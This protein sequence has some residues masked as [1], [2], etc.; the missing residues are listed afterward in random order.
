MKWFECNVKGKDWERLVQADT[1]GGAKATY[2]RDLQD[3]WP[4]IPF[5]AITARLMRGV[6]VNKEEALQRQC[7]DWNR[8][9]PARVRVLFH[10]VIGEP[11]GRERFTKTSAYVLS[12]HTAVIYLEGESG[13]VAL[14]ACEVVEE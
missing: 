10:P 2:R 4:E 14:E 5:T 6:P 13:C 1:A 7:D 12:G 8:L 11:E 9:H 3:A